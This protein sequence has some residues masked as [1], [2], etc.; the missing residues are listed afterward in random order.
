MNDQVLTQPK[1][2][3]FMKTETDEIVEVS[4][5]PM[6]VVA[7]VQQRLVRQVCLDWCSNGMGDECFWEEWPECPTKITLTPHMVLA[8]ISEAN[9]KDMPSAGGESPTTQTT[10]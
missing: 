1:P 6:G 4:P 8:A 2:Y 7:V 10:E 3:T 9:A 5:E